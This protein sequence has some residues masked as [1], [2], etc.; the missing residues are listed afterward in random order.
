[1][2]RAR[3]A[4]HGRRAG[5]GELPHRGGRDVPRQAAVERASHSGIRVRAERRDM[6][7]AAWA[8]AIGTIAAVLV[9]LFYD[10]LRR[11][12]TRPKLKLSI[13]TEP[14]DCMMLRWGQ[15][16]S[17]GRG[18]AHWDGPVYYMRLRIANEGRRK[19]EN[20]Q[21]RVI[22]VDRAM[23]GRY[24]PVQEF[25][26]LNLSW[27]N[28]DRESLL[29]VHRHTFEHCDLAHIHKPSDRSRLEFEE[30]KWDRVNPANTILSIDTAVRSYALPHLQ[31]AG[32]YR[33]HLLMVSDD[34]APIEGIAEIS[35]NGQWY[36]DEKE[37]REKGVTVRLVDVPR[38]GARHRAEVGAV[39]KPRI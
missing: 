15:R 19:A 23:G 13:Q 4:A 12:W 28:R 35:L 20:V 3:G 9:A 11:W 31:P 33:L 8:Q 14:P 38:L 17:M 5:R 21:V 34:T 39:S 1:V 2:R 37:M 25:P 10:P 24:V 7:A 26:P 18:Y 27:A 16:I 30:R 6:E 29:T 22:G 36:D 32:E